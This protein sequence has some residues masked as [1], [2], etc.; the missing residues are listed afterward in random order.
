M[1]TTPTTD[2]TD[3]RV[4][5]T[6]SL[7]FWHGV[8][9]ILGLELRQRVRGASSY[10]LLGIFFLLVGAV[11]TLIIVASGA[12]SGSGVEA[13]GWIYSIAIYFVLLL[14]SLV[15]PALSG[16]A[17]NGDREAGTLA[18]TQV[19]LLSTPQLVIGKFLASW[20]TALAFLVSALP[21]LL[22]AILIG[23]VAPATAV[24]SV[25]VLAF[26]LG[27]V[28]AI[29]VGLS[30]VL[31]RPLMSVVVSYLVIAA[32]AIGSLITFGLLTG[33]TTSTVRTTY[34]YDAED[35]AESDGGYY[36][37]E[38][39]SYTVPRPDLFWGI[40]SVNPFVVLA[41]AVP[42]DLGRYGSPSDGFSGVSL[43]V[44]QM[45]I[46]PELDIRVDC[47]TG[48]SDQYVNRSPQDVFD[49]TVPTWFVGAILHLLLAGG[50]LAWAMARTRTP[51]GRLP[52]GNRVA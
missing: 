8:S 16:N 4:D 37:G 30:G 28:A 11:T 33:V 17:I 41:D 2:T 45:Q 31:G 25:V 49:Q 21:F 50:S 14:G 5:R 20:V 9:I 43:L 26:E 38:D 15:T 34:V 10:V 12:F 29:G 46:A 36:C 48:E 1:T 42:P 47:A 19:T 32:L 23:G 3:A 35:A 40:L 13:G 24:I 44:R 51:A 22:V 7:P 52:R 39:S 27:V 6:E 18:T